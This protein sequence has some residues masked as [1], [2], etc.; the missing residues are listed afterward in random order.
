MA[1]RRKAAQGGNGDIPK[2]FRCSS[3]LIEIGADEEG[4]TPLLMNAFRLPGE[5]PQDK[6]ADALAGDPDEWRWRLY[7]C[8]ALGVYVPAQNIRAMYRDTVSRE[9]VEGQNAKIVLGALAKY[10]AIDV[11]GPMRLEGVPIEIQNAGDWVSIPTIED[12][13][14]FAG[15][16]EYSCQIYRSMVRQAGPTGAPTMRYRPWFYPWRLRFLLW[17]PPVC[18]LS[19]EQVRSWTER[20]GL[21]VG[22]CDGRPKLRKPYC[23]GQFRPLRIEP[24]EDFL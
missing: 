2:D 12:F 14:Y 4:G 20:A 6:K 1:R 7:W 24:A 16:E 3:W 23:Y 19:Y 22:L 9:K 8:S 11:S 13:E 5:K 17:T 21:F 18:R 10:L 15:S